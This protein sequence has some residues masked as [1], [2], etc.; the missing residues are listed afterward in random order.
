MAKVPA[1]DCESSI[2][3]RRENNHDQV[4]ID[5]TKDN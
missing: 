1:I 3:M 4:I 2:G 5:K